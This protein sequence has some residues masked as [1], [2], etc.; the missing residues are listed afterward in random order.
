[1]KKDIV[2]QC[3]RENGIETWKDYS[4]VMLTDYIRK[5]YKCSAYIAKMS[6]IHIFNEINDQFD[7]IVVRDS[8][9][10]KEVFQRYC[11]NNEGL[12]VFRDLNKTDFYIVGILTD[13]TDEAYILKDGLRLSNKKFINITK[14]V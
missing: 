8:R 11:E 4:L 9:K 2:I 10:V 7:S 3:M 1:M 13:R 6:A 14:T 5:N 12:K